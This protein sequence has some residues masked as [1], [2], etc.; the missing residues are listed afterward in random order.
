[1]K[2]TN[3]AKRD[4]G[5]LGLKGIRNV[6]SAPTT[7]FPGMDPYLEDPGIWP[8]FHITLIVA[9]RAELNASLPAGYVA[10][11]DRHVWIEDPEDQIDKWRDSDVFVSKEQLKTKRTRTKGKVAVVEP[12]TIYL[13]AQDRKGKPFLKIT[14]SLDR[15]VITVVELLSPSNKTPGDDRNSYLEK[16][17]EYLSSG[18]NLIEV[19]LL[20]KGKTPPLGDEPP[21]ADYYI[22]A[23][24]AK[25]LP[26]AEI[27]PFSV[28]EVFPDFSLP[29][30]S[31]EQIA[32]NL[33]PCVDRAYRE[34]RYD[35]EIDY[36][37]P[38]VPALAK[39]TAAWARELL[40]RKNRA[41]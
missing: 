37:Q 41:N 40:Q 34:A 21:L 31:G 25:D 3:A 39:E 35:R 33:R 29:L 16:R 13:P 24:R 12:R 27:W 10:S 20:R 11:A 19:N 17:E 38:P 2:C 15:R 30:R 9:M 36:S 4:V 28:R 18:V 14:D 6:K 1:V 23:C 22:L 8:D 7:P 26:R 32:M 5:E